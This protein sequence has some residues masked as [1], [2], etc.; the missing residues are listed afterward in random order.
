M[1]SSG[2]AFV[3]WNLAG[4]QN[5]GP[6]D[7]GCATCTPLVTVNTSSRSTSY[8]IDFYTLGHFSK[9]VLPGACRIYSANASGIIS[10]AFLNPD[11]SKALVA[12]NDAQTS[13]TF[14]VQWGGQSFSYTLPSNA[15]A[16]FT[17][18]GTQNGAPVLS[19]TN[20]IR[21]SSCNYLFD[22]QTEPCTDTL[23]GYDLGYA[24]TGSYAVYQGLD[25]ASGISNVSVRLASAGTG[26]TLEFRLDSPTGPLVASAPI[27]VTG[28]WQDWQTVTG[29][30]PGASG[31]HDLYVVFAGGSSIGNLN[32]FQFSGPPQPPPAPWTTAD[33][34]TVGLAGSTDVRGR[35][36]HGE[37]VR[38]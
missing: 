8:T 11:G 31:V 25:F 16:T 14:Q 1:R 26:G 10:A 18:T 2:K 35:H 12:F 20:Q 9:F 5:D 36:F 13:I 30:G 32:W 17:W 33:I 28:G 19:P 23:G 7:G 3:K 22:L 6:H 4:D 37:W 29:S 27:P 15:G 24:N 21:G 34:G 38:R